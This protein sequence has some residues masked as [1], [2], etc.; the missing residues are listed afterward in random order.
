MF[1]QPLNPHGFVIECGVLKRIQ[2]TEALMVPGGCKVFVSS[3][4]Y[5]ICLEYLQVRQFENTFLFELSR[6]MLC[7]IKMNYKL[8]IPMIILDT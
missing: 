5:S 6:A 8:I 1:K 7:F 3:F 4:E 2:F